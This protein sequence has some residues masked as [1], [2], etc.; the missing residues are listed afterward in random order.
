MSNYLFEN[1]KFYWVK[2]LKHFSKILLKTAIKP[3]FLRSVLSKV[4]WGEDPVP[5][6]SLIDD[7][8]SKNTERFIMKHG[9]TYSLLFVVGVL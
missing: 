2:Y 9:R 4:F 5:T 1:K 3:N 7:V 6:H 8:F